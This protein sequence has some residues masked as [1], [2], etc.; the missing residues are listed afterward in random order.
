MSALPRLV[1][2]GPVPFYTVVL[3]CTSDLA[4]HLFQNNKKNI[5]KIKKDINIYDK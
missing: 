5:V 2:C 4:T 3:F 1:F